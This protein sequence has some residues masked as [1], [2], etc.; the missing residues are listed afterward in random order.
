MFVERAEIDKMEPEQTDGPQI[1][2]IGPTMSSHRDF[3]LKRLKR[4]TDKIGSLQQYPTNLAN[5]FGIS[6]AEYVDF[7]SNYTL[8]FF[9]SIFLILF[10][11]SIVIYYQKKSNLQRRVVNV[12][13]DQNN[14]ITIKLK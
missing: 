6:E 14:E 4:S 8:I 9:S 13:G 3:S 11:L 10:M 12:S 5:R 7:Y 2:Y 1:T